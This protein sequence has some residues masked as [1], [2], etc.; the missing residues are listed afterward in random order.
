MSI[1]VGGASLQGVRSENQDR[2]FVRVSPDGERAIGAIA[3]GIGGLADGA[4][5]A[6]AAVD[7]VEAFCAWLFEADDPSPAELRER[8]LE[9]YRHANEAIVERTG[10][11]ARSGTTLVFI[12]VTENHRIVANVG[13][14]RAFRLHGGELKRMT[15][16]HSVVE[17]LVRDGA[18]TPEQ[19]ER[20]PYRNLLTRSLGDAGDPEVDVESVD[21]DQLDTKPGTAVILTSDGV[22][23][24]PGLLSAEVVQQAIDEEPNLN[25]AAERLCQAAIDAGSRDNAT[26]VIGR[27]V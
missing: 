25:A 16:D 11:R 21:R 5:A 2:F 8:V 4:G 7:A 10:S 17:E 24:V 14:S 23:D 22:H 15:I 26:M 13:D 12:A 1:E 19:A 18:L 3:D 9:L 27:K 6:A 20:S